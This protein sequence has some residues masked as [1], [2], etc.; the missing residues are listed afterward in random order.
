MEKGVQKMFCLRHPSN[1]LIYGPSQTGKSTLIR[2]MIKRNIYSNNFRKIKWCYSYPDEWFLEEPQ[3]EFVRGLPKS[4]ESNELIIIDDL[5][6]NLSDKIAE[7]FTVASHHCNVSVIL[8]LQ[9]LFPRCKVARD[10]SLNSHYMLLF[11]NARDASQI[12]CIGR[13]IYPKNS[14]YF[15]DAYLKATSSPYKYLV[16][17]LHPQT[18]EQYR[19]RDGLFPD[20]NGVY[21]LYQPL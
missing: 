21:W 15:I 17:D 16:V 2:E 1:C 13:Q 4:Y 11:K 14:K 8:V 5:M 19:L 6:H 12:G 18:E 7:L 3:I 9:N 10:I 20:E